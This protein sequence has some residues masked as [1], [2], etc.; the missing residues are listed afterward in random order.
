MLCND[1]YD[2]STLVGFGS[3]VSVRRLIY[4]ILNVCPFDYTAFVVIVKAGI[5]LTGLTTPGGCRYSKWP[6]HK[7]V[8]NGCVIEHL[9]GV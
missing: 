8:H 6:R 9:S 5:L 1:F 7:L 4:K 2:L 3:S